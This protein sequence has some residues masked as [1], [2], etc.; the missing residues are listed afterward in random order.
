[1]SVLKSLPTGST[2]Q[3]IEHIARS[4]DGL[5]FNPLLENI[6]YEQINSQNG[7]KIYLVSNL[8]TGQIVLSLQESD[9]AHLGV[10]NQFADA[11]NNQFILPAA[12]PEMVDYIAN[13]WTYPVWANRKPGFVYYLISSQFDVNLNIS[14]SD[15]P[16]GNQAGFVDHFSA[17]LLGK[18]DA[19][20]YSGNT[21]KLVTSQ[22]ITEEMVNAMQTPV[23]M[24]GDIQY[25]MVPAGTALSL[26]LNRKSKTGGTL[27]AINISGDVKLQVHGKVTVIA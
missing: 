21:E 23:S 24:V 10:D 12:P 16:V 4:V 7:L 18:N 5:A 11:E 3:K 9:W 15:I 6:Q 2:R 27:N 14:K 19:V 17:T 22:T 13:N 8:N 26:K 1:M 25:H 20:N